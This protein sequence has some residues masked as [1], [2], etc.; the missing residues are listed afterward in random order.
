MCQWWPAGQGKAK[1]RIPSKPPGSKVHNASKFVTYENMGVRK[2]WGVGVNP[3]KLNL[4]E[5]GRTYWGGK[6]HERQEGPH[7]PP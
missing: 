3:K 2:G 4:E 1:G 5:S 6:T 7:E